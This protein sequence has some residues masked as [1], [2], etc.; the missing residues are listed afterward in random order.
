MGKEIERKFLVKKMPDFEST[1]SRIEQGYLSIEKERV[2]R[3]RLN[4]GTNHKTA[5][6]TIKGNLLINQGKISDLPKTLR[7]EKEIIFLD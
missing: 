4:Y 3:V 5:Y 2:V 1:G 7:V 6:L